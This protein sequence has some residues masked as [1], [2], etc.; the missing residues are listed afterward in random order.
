MPK[1][2]YVT[3]S[4]R[5]HSTSSELAE[6]YLS[7]LRRLNPEVVVDHLDLWAIDLPPFNGSRVAAKMN[8]IAGVEQQN[9]LQRTVW[10]EI[11]E[12]AQRFINADRYVFAVPMWNGGVPYRLKQYIDVIHQPGLLWR[13]DHDAGY[14]GLLKNKQ[15]T[16]ILTAAVFAPGMPGAFGV[17]HHS[18]YLRAWLSQAGVDQ[19]DEVRFQPSLL[20]DDPAAELKAAHARAAAL[21]REHSTL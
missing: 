2:L 7:D 10:D 15:A 19:V 16:L 14:F 4:P 5:E 9:E 20:V 1:I 18:T 11:V 6:S 12:H 3:A 8:V 13:L 17:D 21:A